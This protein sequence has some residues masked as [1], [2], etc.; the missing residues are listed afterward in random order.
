MSDLCCPSLGSQMSECK[1]HGLECP[2]NIVRYYDGRYYK[3]Y[4]L[5]IPAASG[6]GFYSVRYCPFCGSALPHW[7]DLDE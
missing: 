3:G 2:D 4:G 6:G 5:H 7:E 1:N